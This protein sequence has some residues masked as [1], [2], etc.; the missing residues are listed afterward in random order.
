M[1]LQATLTTLVALVSLAAAGDRL[2]VTIEEDL[3]R[4]YKYFNGTWRTAYGTHP[5]D[6]RDGCQDPPHIPGMNTLCL[7]YME[8]HSRGHF[9]FDRQ[10]KRC[11]KFAGWNFRFPCPPKKA[12]YTWYLDELPCTW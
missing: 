2:R 10:R 9:Y 11:I 4:N 8:E 3:D 1:R 6:P 7:D 5:V 12:C